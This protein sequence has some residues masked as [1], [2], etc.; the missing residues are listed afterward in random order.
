[1]VGYQQITRLDEANMQQQFTMVNERDPESGRLV[2]S[3]AGLP[4][5]YTQAPDTASLEKNMRE[6]I[7][8]DVDTVADVAGSRLA[9][10]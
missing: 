9:H 2:G 7:Q 10:W 5:C 4:G 6:A 3:V 8:V 1:M